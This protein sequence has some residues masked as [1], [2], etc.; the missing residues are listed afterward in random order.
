MPK[1]LSFADNAEKEL[2]ALI[3]HVSDLQSFKEIQSV[4]IPLQFNTKLQQTAEL[5]GVGKTKA[6][7]MRRKMH[8]ALTGTPIIAKPNGGRRRQNMTLEEEMTLLKTLE[9]SASNGEHIDSYAIKQAYEEQLGRTVHLST[10]TRLLARHS[11]RKLAPRKYHPKQD[12]EAQ[13]TFKKTSAKLLKKRRN[14]L[15]IAPKK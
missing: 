7:K 4:L 8:A 3:S 10:I 6:A 15:R 1:K 12:I 9:K 5:L 13:E 14:N 11:W 2:I